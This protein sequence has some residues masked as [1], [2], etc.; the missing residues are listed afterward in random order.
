MNRIGNEREKR[1]K[2]K[3]KKPFNSF[4]PIDRR[5]FHH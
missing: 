1:F 5:Q 2:E 4:I 3:R